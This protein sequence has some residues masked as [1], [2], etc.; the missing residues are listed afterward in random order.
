MK[1]SKFD[2]TRFIKQRTKLFS[3]IDKELE[4]DSHH[5]SY[6]GALDI[7]FNNRFC[8]DDYDPD[9]TI[10]L[11]CYVAPIK[12]RGTNFASQDDLDTFLTEWERE[13]DESHSDEV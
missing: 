8:Y 11:H 6:E 4:I 7:V 13:L 9:I 10:H 1:F 3:L 2:N 5:K 12:G